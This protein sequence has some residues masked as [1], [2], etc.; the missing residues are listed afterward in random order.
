M[1]AR[2]KLRLQQTALR[3]RLKEK[4]QRCPNAGH[5][6]RRK[7]LAVGMVEAGMSAREIAWHFG[8]PVADVQAWIDATNKLQ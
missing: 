6:V 3:T 4:D 1:K 8:W 7:V 2:I 5:K